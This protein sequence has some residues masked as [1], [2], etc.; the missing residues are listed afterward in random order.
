[1][2]TYKRNIGVDQKDAAGAGYARNIGADQTDDA[3]SGYEDLAVTS[4]GTGGGSATLLC[5]VDLAVTAGG[6]G[7]GTA[8]LLAFA[9]VD[10]S[11]A[12]GGVGGGSVSVLSHI[13]VL[14]PTVSKHHVVVAGNNQLWYEE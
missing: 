3:A 1:M 2:A 4:G 12:A 6:T 13:M 9:Y 7:G 10:M 8:T 11:I 5:D 14:T